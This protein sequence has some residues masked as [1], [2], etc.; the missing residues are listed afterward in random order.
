[1]GIIWN[2]QVCHR[3]NESN[4]LFKY[5][6]SVNL[7]ILSSAEIW[8]YRVNELQNR[9][10]PPI[11]LSHAD[12]L[13]HSYYCQLKLNVH[14]WRWV[15]V[16]FFCFLQ[17]SEIHEELTTS[18]QKYTKPQT[19]QP[20]GI[21]RVT[22]TQ[23]CPESWRDSGNSSQQQL[24]SEAQNKLSNQNWSKQMLTTFSEVLAVK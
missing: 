21:C 9:C 6:L 11:C 7:W 12:I 20:T 24:S 10:P 17:L 13:C 4:I 14:S 19:I 1:M 23:L 2:S 8:K 5:H 18:R 16:T 22:I 15:H 3:G